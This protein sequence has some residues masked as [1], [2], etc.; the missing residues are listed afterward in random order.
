M[1][2][3]GFTF[4]GVIFACLL[5]WSFDRPARFISVYQDNP[6]QVQDKAFEVLENK[7]N[8]CHRL[9]KPDFVFTKTNMNTFAPL[10]YTQVFVKKKMPKGKDYPLS[11]ADKTALTNW[12]SLLEARY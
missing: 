7:C 11:T 5:C 12:L 9:K 1:D 10:I 6:T 3:K 2:L 8:E 4:F